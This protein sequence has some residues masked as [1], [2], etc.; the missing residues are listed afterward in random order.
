MPQALLPL[1]HKAKVQGLLVQ[2]ARS[3][4]SLG[5]EASIVQLEDGRIGILARTRVRLLGLIPVQR[6]RMIGYFGPQATDL[7]RPELDRAEGM[8][9][10][11]VGVTPEFLAGPGGAEV[12]VSVWVHP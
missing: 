8:R 5:D 11:V 2:V 3:G 10:R 9:L 12:H 4:L 7:I 1:I 6:Q